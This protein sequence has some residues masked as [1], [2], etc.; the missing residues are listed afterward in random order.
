M[1]TRAAHAA[2]YAAA[3]LLLFVLSIWQLENDSF[4]RTAN[5]RLI[6]QYMRNV[7]SV[8]SDDLYLSSV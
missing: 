3:K 7:V 6:Y 2:I 1:Q 5:N 8:H 4:L